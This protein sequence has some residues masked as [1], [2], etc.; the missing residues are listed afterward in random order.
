MAA[1]YF[2]GSFVETYVVNE[3]CKSFKN[4]AVNAGFFYYRDKDWNEIDLVV[5]KD[6]TLYPVEI[7]TGTKYDSKAVKAFRKLEGSR[8]R[9]G[10]GV[11]VC[12]TESVYPV[13]DNVYAVPISAL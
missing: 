10:P 4:N 7:K 9:I 11:V 12:N 2:A 13:T 1:S 8:Y 6:G 5:L 3:I